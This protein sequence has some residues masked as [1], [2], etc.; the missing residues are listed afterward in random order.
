ME[1][2]DLSWLNFSIYYFLLFRA[3]QLGFKEGYSHGIQQGFSDGYHTGYEKGWQIGEEVLIYKIIEAFCD[4]IF[5]DWFLF[6]F[7]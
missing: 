2:Y 6:G 3:H 4:S 7:C 1:A 5:L